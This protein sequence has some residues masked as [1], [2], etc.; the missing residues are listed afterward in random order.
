M[1]EI[2]ER[3]LRLLSQKASTSL[4]ILDGPTQTQ[5]LCGQPIAQLLWW[6]ALTGHTTLGI[7]LVSYAGQVQFAISCDAAL[8]TD[9]TA[10]A[11]DMATA[12]SEA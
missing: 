12:A 2:E 1:T 3:S 9:A 11:A 7:S 5:L 8:D 10:L 4:A 6:P